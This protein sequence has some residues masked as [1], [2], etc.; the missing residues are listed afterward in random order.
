MKRRRKKGSEK[1]IVYTEKR[2]AG[3]KESGEGTTNE[4]VKYRKSRQSANSRTVY[5]EEEGERGDPG[6]RS[7]ESKWIM[8]GSIKSAQSTKHSPG[9]PN[10]IT[11]HIFHDIPN[12]QRKT[13]L[14]QSF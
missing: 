11:I 8:I 7:R 5:G 13:P 6:Q 10:R 3:G 1:A 4:V 12:L 2:E 14:S 9:A